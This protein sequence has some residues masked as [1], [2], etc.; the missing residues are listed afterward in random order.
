[1]LC[2]QLVIMLFMTLPWSIIG[3]KVKVA[4][5]DAAEPFMVYGSKVSCCSPTTLIC[6]SVVTAAAG[7]HRLHRQLTQSVCSACCR[8]ASSAA[9]P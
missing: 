3:A 7:K 4:T 6:H 5:L 8:L 1:M 2:R 9:M